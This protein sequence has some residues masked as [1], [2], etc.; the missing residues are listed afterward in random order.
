MPH[1][2]HE[3]A[4]PGTAWIGANDGII[5]SILNGG[6]VNA[7]AVPDNGGVCAVAFMEAVDETDVD[8]VEWANSR[9]HVVGVSKRKSHG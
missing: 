8:L 7:D 6:K 1:R 3:Y 9:R 2:S 5:E 4:P